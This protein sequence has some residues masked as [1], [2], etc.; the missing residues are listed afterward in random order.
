MAAHAS[1]AS[2]VPVTPEMIHA[3]ATGSYAILAAGR[4]AADLADLQRRFH[5]ERERILGGTRRIEEERNRRIRG[6][7]DKDGWPALTPV[8]QSPNGLWIVPLTNPRELVAEGAEGKDENGVPGLNH[9]VGG[10][11]AK[12]RQ[13]DCHIVSVRRIG[14]DGRYERISTVEFLPV[15]SA[16]DR[17]SVRQNMAR[18]NSKP[19]ADAIDAV[20]WYVSAVATGSVPLNWEQ[21]KAFLEG[22]V[23]PDDGV[24]RLCG[25]DWRDRDLLNAA[26]GPWGPFV[27][28]GF[29]NMGLDAVMASPPVASVTALVPPEILLAAGR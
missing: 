6:E 13:C 14:E 10:Y 4:N 19:P 24:E 8:V 3:A 29:R 20:S 18:G 16:S 25:Y 28:P 26:V 23:L 22:Q 1:A 12:A 27:V 21:I 17:L 9:C 7:I 5:Q 2:D 15:R 11:A